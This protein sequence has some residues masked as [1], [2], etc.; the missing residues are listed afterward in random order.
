MATTRRR[1]T[2]F[3]KHVLQVARAGGTEA[4]AISAPDALRKRNIASLSRHQQINANYYRKTAI[5]T[6]INDGYIKRKKSI[7]GFKYLELT[8]KGKDQLGRY[9]LGEI[10]IKQPKRW[11]GKYRVIIF[12]IK[13]RRRKTRDEIRLWLIELGFVRIQQ[14]V[15]AY[16]HECQEVITLLKTHYGI[17]KDL[18]YLVVE[19]IEND[20]WLKQHFNLS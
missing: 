7:A 12:D 19:T 5:D 17:G 11:D 9:E 16:P 1:L 18:L 6:L 15:W 14:S 10:T 20:R 2:K 3:L 13:E 4:L 8:T